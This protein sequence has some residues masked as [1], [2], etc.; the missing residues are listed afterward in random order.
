MA[1]Q[2]ASTGMF[3]FQ[4]LMNDFYGSK[5]EAGTEAALA[6]QA[7]QGNMIQS[8]LDSQL[9]MQLGQFNQG[10]A[11][12]NMSHQADLEQRNQSALMKDEFTYGMQQ[13]EAQFGFQNNYAN[14]QHDR[15]LGMVSAQ[16][17]QNRL[18]QREQGQQDRL[19]T[20]TEGEQ[21]RLIDSQNNKSEEK[22]ATGDYDA[23]RDVA[24]TNKES[25]L[26]QAAIGAAADTQVAETDARCKT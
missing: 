12:G 2:Q 22:I 20:I 7:F 8:A 16:G 14:A 9:A 1:K 23:R 10:I 3:N 11:Q 25:A 15:D 18:G 6:K 19:Q 24:Q 26:G 13:M 17:E 21:Q 4:S 5:P